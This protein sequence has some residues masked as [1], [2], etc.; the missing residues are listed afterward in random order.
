MLKVLIATKNV[1]KH[2]FKRKVWKPSGY[3]YY[4]LDG[5]WLLE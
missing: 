1:D 4:R 5:D 3:Q 2:I